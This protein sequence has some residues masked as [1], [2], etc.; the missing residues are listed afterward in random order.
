MVAWL[1]FPSLI[2]LV[3]NGYALIS[4][5]LY[6]RTPLVNRPIIYSL[7]EVQ[8][9]VIV[10]NGSES[11]A[12]DSASYSDAGASK[13]RTTSIIFVVGVILSSIL[14]L[15]TIIIAGVVKQELMKPSHNSNPSP[16]QTNETTNAPNDLSNL[17]DIP[18][19]EPL[20][21]PDVDWTQEVANQ[22]AQERRL[23]SHYHRGIIS[24]S[25]AAAFNAFAVLYYCSNF[26]YKFLCENLSS[27]N[28]AWSVGTSDDD[29]D[30]PA[31]YD[32]GC[33]YGT[34]IDCVTASTFFMILSF[35]PYFRSLNYVKDQSKDSSYTESFTHVTSR[36][37][38]AFSFSLCFIFAVLAVAVFPSGVTRTFLADTDFC[39]VDGYPSENLESF[40]R[41]LPETCPTGD[42]YSSKP[43]SD[44]TSVCE[45]CD[46]TCCSSSPVDYRSYFVNTTISVGCGERLSSL[47]CAAC[48]P[49]ARVFVDDFDVRTE[50][51]QPVHVC[52]LW[53]SVVWEECGH[54]V[55]KGGEH[56][57]EKVMQA[58]KEY[59]D[60][61]CEIELNLGEVRSGL[62]DDDCFS[63][64]ETKSA[65]LLMCVLGFILA[66]TLLLVI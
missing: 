17:A 3:L 4:G 14:A 30:R 31:D 61:V 35:V 46:M 57:G 41:I 45:L 7:L 6:T 58:Y 9:Y 62:F 18:T 47:N 49:L 13:L 33:S 37:A 39:D 50:E 56:E 28:D 32:V 44:D 36:Q 2:S 15:T 60:S 53:C 16:S 26:P 40:S 1:F 64:A 19:A 65:S 22:K 59:D 29:E 63:A 38:S 5:V 34:S 24:T 8:S 54:A 10:D 42:G 43:T 66:T 48:S 20:L 55:F 21:I 25:L 23:I 52:Q 51:K 12:L 27:D 11:Q